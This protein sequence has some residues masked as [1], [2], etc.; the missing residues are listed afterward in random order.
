M[1]TS[2]SLSYV[3]GGG[4]LLAGASTSTWVLAPHARAPRG[5]WGL[6]VLTLEEVLLSRDFNISQCRAIADLTT[7][8]RV[9]LLPCLYPLGCLLAGFSQLGPDLP[10]RG[11]GIGSR[12]IGGR[13][14]EK[15]Q[16]A[17]AL[18]G[19]PFSQDSED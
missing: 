10:V 17:F 18:I 5:C 6:R 3:H 1:G 2:G 13:G 7:A 11:V 15:T 16:I 9:R 8:V 4:L 19:V 14:D 12:G